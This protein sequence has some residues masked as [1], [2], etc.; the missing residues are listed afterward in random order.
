[1]KIL[2]KTINDNMRAHSAS[3]S[4]S[5]EIIAAS[6]SIIDSINGGGKIL[7]MG[8]GG[9]ATD[10]SHM[11]SEFVGRFK[12]KRSPLPAIALTT[13][14]AIITAISNDFSYDQVFARQCEAL[15]KPGDVVIAIST[16]GMSNNVIKA[17]SQYKKNKSIIVVSLT[18]ISGG[19]LSEISDI[20][21]K[22][23]S[24]TTAT[25]QE[26]HRTIIHIICDIIDEYY[27]KK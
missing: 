27:A 4:L 14:N 18:G 8:N 2:K 17:V 22:V 9:S 6:K 5:Q 10:A 11:A 21:I 12:R 3:L 1:M 15:I 24:K 19:K 26:V 7:I 23:P 20:A 13:D 16:S 25:I